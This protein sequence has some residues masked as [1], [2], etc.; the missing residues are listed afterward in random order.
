MRIIAGFAKSVSLKAGF[1]KLV[2]PTTDRIKETI[3]NILGDFQNAR[4][5]DLFAGSGALGLEALS[6]GAKEVYFVEKDKK[7]CI[8]IKENLEKV[9]RASDSNLSVSVKVFPINYIQV[10]KLVEDKFDY[11]FADPPY[12]NNGKIATELLK[13]VAIFDLL[14]ESGQ[15]ILEHPSSLLVEN[16][17][18]QNCCNLV[19]QK[20]FG[21]TTFSFFTRFTK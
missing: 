15:L 8:T 6:R 12:I 7:S 3:F 20:R 10:V 1:S 16:Y 14:K 5:V 17:I 4:V 18:E 21:Q 19:K 13:N 2:R 9:L 11:I